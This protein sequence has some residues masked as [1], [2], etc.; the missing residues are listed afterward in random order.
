MTYKLENKVKQNGIVTRQSGS[1]SCDE[2]GFV[3]ITNDNI[4]EQD[5]LL[6]EGEIKYFKGELFYIE[7]QISG[8]GK[9]SMIFAKA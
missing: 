3:E 7:G 8:F 2:E 4:P 5:F 9:V 6:C 1:Y